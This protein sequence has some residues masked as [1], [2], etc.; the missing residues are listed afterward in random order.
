MTNVLIPNIGRRGYLVRYLKSS[1]EFR[2]KV[3]VSDCDNTASGLYGDNDGAFI[4]PKP[5]DDEFKYVEKL[6]ELCIKNN[7]NVIIPVID[8][9]IDILSR[10]RDVFVRDKIFVAVSTE[11]VLNICY[12]KLKMNSF[13]D[14]NGF[15]VPRT[16]TE[17]KE[18][19]QSIK[20]EEV[21]F[22]VILKPIYGSG[23][24]STYKVTSMEEVK[25]LFQKGMMIQ[26]YITGVEYGIDVFN[27]MDG[28]P[29]RCI[30][31][32]KIS[33][34]SGETDKAESVLN[35]KIKKLIISLGEKLG[36]VCNLDCDVL[37]SN[38][39]L[40]VIDLNPRFGGGY[41]AT[42]EAGVNLLDL[43]IRL[44]RGESLNAEFDNYKVGVYTF[45]EVCVT[46]TNKL[47]AACGCK[48]E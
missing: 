19:E 35:Q 1:R 46:T 4:L 43:V 24:V 23:S 27:N 3:F 5:K 29:I 16:F 36:H 41:P 38:G 2:G 47:I 31:K 15:E 22:P 42:H 20:R 44:S 25:T 39:H 33:M 34:R 37:E 9:E 14:I 8:P 45:K 7:I 26:Q 6:H 18:F 17:V 48:E 21:F 28:K 11:R 40:Y 32:K 30:V 12:N 10:H 13:L